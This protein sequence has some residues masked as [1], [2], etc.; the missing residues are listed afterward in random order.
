MNLPVLGI[1]RG[2][3]IIGLLNGSNLKKVE[4]HVNVRH[5][6]LNT[7]NNKESIKNSYH[8]FSLSECPKNFKVTFISNDREIEAIKHNH[9][10]ILGIMWHPERENIFL[11]EDINL[12]TCV[13]G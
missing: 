6:V 7:S 8:S 11:E 4:S 9:K 5:N 13:F 10:K 2:M 3:Q 12:F 1:C